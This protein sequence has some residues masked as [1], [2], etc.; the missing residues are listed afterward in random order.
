MRPKGDIQEMIRPAIKILLI[1]LILSLPL[2]CDKGAKSTSAASAM[3]EAARSKPYIAS[4]W[5]DPFHR[6]TCKWAKKIS[7]GNAAGY[8]TREA[9]AKDGHRPCKVCKP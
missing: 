6:S 2:A 5:R 1:G 9:A 7:D 3:G 4:V 8:D